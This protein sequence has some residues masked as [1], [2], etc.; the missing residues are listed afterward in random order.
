MGDDDDAGMDRPADEHV[1][2]DVIYGRFNGRTQALIDL[3]GLCL[4]HSSAIPDDEDGLDVEGFRK[5]VLAQVN[6]DFPEWS[7]LIDQ[8]RSVK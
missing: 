2:V 1:R 4:F 5:S 7:S 6:K 8:I 3:A